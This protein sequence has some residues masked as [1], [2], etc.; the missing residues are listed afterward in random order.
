MQLSEYVDR[1]SVLAF[2][3]SAA[4]RTPDMSS[5][6]LEPELTAETERGHSGPREARER[7]DVDDN[8]PWQLSFELAG[9]IDDVEYDVEREKVVR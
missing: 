9:I 3:A 7:D 8:A 6:D 5:P 1:P 4:Y 2:P